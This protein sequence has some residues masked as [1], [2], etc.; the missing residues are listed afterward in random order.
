MFPLC[1]LSCMPEGT[2]RNRAP[3]CACT[4][5]LRR[6]CLDLGVAALRFG[7]VEHC[8][9]IGPAGRLRLELGDKLGLA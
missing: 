6:S 5:T 9:A 7:F 2:L 4:N 3:P 8:M 1:L